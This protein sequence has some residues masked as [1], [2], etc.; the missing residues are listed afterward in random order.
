MVVSGQ[1]SLSGSAHSPHLPLAKNGAISQL[2]AAHPCCAFVAIGVRVPKRLKKIDIHNLARV[3][4]MVLHQ[5]G[6]PA[7]QADRSYQ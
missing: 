3:V 4:L 1:A 5:G 2:L 6:S 7:H